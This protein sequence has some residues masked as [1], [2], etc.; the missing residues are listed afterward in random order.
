MFICVAY[1][2]QILL[3]PDTDILIPISK[4]L[5]VKLTKY[6]VL[7]KQCKLLKKSIEHI[8]I[9]LFLLLFK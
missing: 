8:E 1:D 3:I 2:K 9:N 6:Q 4:H 5:E 7:T